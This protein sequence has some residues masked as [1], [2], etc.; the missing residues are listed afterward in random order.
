MT[1]NVLEAIKSQGVVFSASFE[2]RLHDFSYIG[3]TYRYALPVEL[4]TDYMYSGKHLIF[5]GSF[6][7]SLAVQ[8]S[9]CLTRVVYPVELPFEE[10]FSKTD[11]E[12]YEITGETVSLDRMVED[13]ILL[14]LPA[15]FLCKEDCK[16]LCPECGADLNKQSCGCIGRLAGKSNPFAVLQKLLDENK[17]V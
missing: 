9:R 15:K 17:E 13:N 16:G 11:P 5:T 4:R 6:K 1:I 10:T 8:C 2:E 7:T 3:S 14:N 12:S